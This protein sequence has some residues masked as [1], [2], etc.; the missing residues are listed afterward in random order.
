MPPL[1][2]RVRHEFAALALGYYASGR[3]ALRAGAG[4]LVSAH[5]L[6]H[7]VE[8]VLKA[9]LARHTTLAEMKKFGHRLP[10]LFA[11]AEARSAELR[12]DEHRATASRLHEL[13]ESRFP[14]R[15]LSEAAT[16][17]FTPGELGKA[18]RAD[19]RSGTTTGDVLEL[20]RIDRLFCASFRAAGLN[21]AAFMERLGPDARQAIRA[22]NPEQ[23]FLTNA[24]EGT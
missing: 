20:G 7:A 17:S 1:P 22:G 5:V 6:H 16:F 4:P 12:S 23:D 8:F 24:S 11:S 19:V 15:I 2:D 14:D 10:D 18:G 21:P 3:L 9:T 13:W